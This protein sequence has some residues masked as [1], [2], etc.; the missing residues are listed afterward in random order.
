MFSLLNCLILAV[1][2][3]WT[4]KSPYAAICCTDWGRGR[5]H[6][7]GMEWQGEALIRGMQHMLASQRLHMVSDTRGSC[8]GHTTAQTHGG[9]CSARKTLTSW[10]LNGK[11]LWSLCNSFQA[12]HVCI[13][14]L[15]LIRSE[16]LVMDCPLINTWL[17]FEWKWLYCLATIVSY[18]CGFQP[19]RDPPCRPANGSFPRLKW[20]FLCLTGEA[21]GEGEWRREM[22]GA[23]AWCKSLFSSGSFQASLTGACFPPER[24]MKVFL[25]HSACEIGVMSFADKLF[26]VKMSW[27]D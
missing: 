13:I 7:R 26:M 17:I 18:K 25:G 20:I 16:L 6:L 21:E 4:V 24:Q 2:C 27:G 12:C 1:G 9:V 3:E 23:A 19:G 22:E 10:R 11:E 8:R 5:V 14:K 15:L